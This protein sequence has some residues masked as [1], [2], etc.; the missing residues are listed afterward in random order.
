MGEVLIYKLNRET[1]L[2]KLMI[3]YGGWHHRR[4][5]TVINCREI[6]EPFKGKS[7]VFKVSNPSWTE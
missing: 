6:G 2:L 4:E 7:P 1:D 5:D 3:I